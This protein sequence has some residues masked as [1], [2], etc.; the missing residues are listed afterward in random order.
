MARKWDE[1]EKDRSEAVV[2]IGD[3]ARFRK[4]LL[5]RDI[6]WRMKKVY[7]VGERRVIV[8]TRSEGE[9]R[10]TVI[11]WYLYIDADG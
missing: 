7:T 6:S 1:I 5:S 3:W 10:T 2:D 8:R 4:T 11:C 9:E